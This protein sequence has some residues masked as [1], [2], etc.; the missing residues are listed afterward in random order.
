MNQKT[1]AGCGIL[2]LFLLRL[3]NCW[4]LIQFLNRGS[5]SFF[6]L[7]SSNI[8]RFRCIHEVLLLRYKCYNWI[9]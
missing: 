3:S 1:D 9:N 2:G 5:F 4:T 7:F 6:S 8:L